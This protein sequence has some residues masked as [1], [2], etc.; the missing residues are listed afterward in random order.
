MT[1]GCGTVQTTHSAMPI[2]AD[3][4]RWG[5]DAATSEGKRRPATGLLRSE[6]Q[7]LPPLERRKLL[8]QTR[9]AARNFTVAAWMVRRH[10]DYVS[11]FNLQ[12]KGPDDKFA[13]LAEERMR[14]WSK[15]EN[16][17]IRGRFSFPTKIRVTEARGVLDG[18]CGLHLLADGRLQGIEGDR[19][20]TPIGGL[21]IDVDPLSVVHGVQVNEYGRALQYCITKRTRASD[22]SPNGQDFQFERMVPAHQ[23]YLHGY[24]ERFDQT[25]GIS[26]LAPAINTLLDLYEGIDYALARLKLSQLFGLAFY[27]GDPTSIASEEDREDGQ[28]YMQLKLGRKPIILDMDVGDRVEFLES[29]TPS[30]EFQT[31]TGLLIQLV[32]KALDIP[33]S[34]FSEDF[35]NYS[36]A[37]QALL[38]YEQSAEIKRNN[39]RQML[40]TITAWRLRLFMLAGELPFVPLDQVKWEWVATGIPWIDPLKEVQGDLAA[41]SGALTSRTRILKARGEDFETIAD[42]LERENQML[43]DRKLSTNTSP[44]QALIRELAANG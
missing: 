7:E 22:F 39:V 35:T 23:F 41:L 33:F 6:D 36:G 5:Y 28:D 40:D 37:R 29:R 24:F 16:C 20:R 43:A 15:A 14:T 3:Y 13:R 34:F 4:G 8:S 25:R 17:D 44:D 32:L 2:A 18:D 31:F 10:L 27:R 42:E 30:S 38:Q 19:V 9:E 12:I 11:S 21:P 26:P 1:F